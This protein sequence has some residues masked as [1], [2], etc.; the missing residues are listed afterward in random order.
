MVPPEGQDAF[1]NVSTWIVLRYF[2]GEPGACGLCATPFF[3]RAWWLSYR[4][5]VPPF[6]PGAY[7]ATSQG[8]WICEDCCLTQAPA[9][10]QRLHEEE[11]DD[12]IVT[13]DARLAA[14]ENPYH[15]CC[16]ACCPPWEGRR[17]QCP[18]TTQAPHAEVLW[19][20]QHCTC[21]RRPFWEYW[22]GRDRT[23]GEKISPEAPA[24]GWAI[25][26]ASRQLGQAPGMSWC[27]SG[28]HTARRGIAR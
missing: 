17:G 10:H 1:V 25:R 8:A 15:Q 12:V 20:L 23:T 11:L 16:R 7:F 19:A 26:L 3:D 27:L 4:G 14:G 18:L 24:K 9:L 6:E 13:G 21:A 2:A 5:R 28:R 22:E